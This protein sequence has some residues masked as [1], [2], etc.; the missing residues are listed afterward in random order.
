MS[1]SIWRIF[2][3]ISIICSWAAKATEDGKVTLDEG[4]DLL[5]QL[6]EVLGVRTEFDVSVVSSYEGVENK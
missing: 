3:F 4:V 6:C 2:T 5:K 1:I